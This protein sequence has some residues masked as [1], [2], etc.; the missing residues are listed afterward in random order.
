MSQIN[1]RDEATRAHV[2]RAFERKVRRS[3]WALLF[4]R[5]WPRLWLLIGI[6][7]LFAV[8]SVLGVWPHLGDMAHYGVLGGFGLLTL[9]AFIYIVRTPWPSREEG[10]RRIERIS[11][12]AH[13]PASSYEDTLSG[14][15]TGGVSEKLWSAHRARLARA[16]Q[17]LKVGTPAPRTHRFD[18]FALRSVA[19]LALVL[20]GV[21]SGRELGGYLQEAFR[22]SDARMLAAARLDAWVTPPGYTGKAPIM[23]ADGAREASATPLPA[24]EGALVVPVRSVLIVRSSGVR[25]LQPELEVLATGSNEPERITSAAANTGTGGEGAAATVAAS[26]GTGSSKVTELRYEL[27]KSA[28]VRV[29]ALGSEMAAWTFDVTPDHPPKISMIKPPERSPRGSMKLTYKV[30][31]DYG[32]ASAQAHVAKIRPKASDVEKSVGAWA[33]KKLTGPRPPH[34]PPPLLALKLPRSGATDAESFTHLELGSHP[35][36]GMRVEMWL[37]AKDV[38][39]QTGKSERLEIVLP[40][41]RFDNPVARAVIE[42]RRKLAEDPRNRPDILKALE[43]LTLEPEGFLDDIPAFIGLRMAYYRLKNSDSRADRNSAIEQLW[44]VA[45]RIEDGD[46]SEAERRL[47]EAQ[48][49]LSKLLEKGASD[50]E[51]ADAMKELREALNEYM[52]ELAEQNQQQQDQ[53]VDGQNKDQQFLSSRDLEQMMKQIEEMA[54]NGSREQAQ[55]M[56]SELRDLLDRLQSSKQTAEQGRRNREMMEKMD[57][58]GKLVGKQ[59]QLMDDTFSELRQED[60][61]GERGERGDQQQQ[62]RQ[63]GQQGRQGRQ[64]QQGQQGKRGGQQGEQGQQG[65]GRRG[66]RGQG[67]SD[68]GGGLGERQR[69]LRDELDRLQR[70]LD[71]LGLG[72]SDQLDDARRAMGEAE[73]ALGDQD[74]S[75][76][77]EQQARALDQLRKGAQSMAQQMLQNMPQR[78]GRNGDTPRDPLGRPQRSQGPDLGTSVKVPDEIDRQRARE[79]LQELRRRIGQQTRPPTELDYIERLLKRF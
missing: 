48:D 47:L 76:A 30:H 36:A 58:L 11:G 73:S 59:Q 51:I 71:E 26:L 10:L 6:A 28:R 21:A 40:Q 50:Q 78:Y 61:R 68:Q 67:P 54:K 33:T 70:G 5:M 77:T 27:T 34:E 49:K 17:Q 12:V 16:M 19:V 7:T 39:G 37:E 42:Q 72:R 1:S 22:F 55:Q 46:L 44:N 63:G 14:A 60:R 79:I 20:V 23:L 32:V 13:R 66:E 4:E 18:P 45:V 15:S 56:L 52:R 65:Q 53:F 43:A 35:W 29:M 3:S 75:T 62:G 31:D 57:E 9:A 24:A 8:L 64:G 41:R 25:D 69:A 74:Y 38:A 2:E